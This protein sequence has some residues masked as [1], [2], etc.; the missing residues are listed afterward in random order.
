M[1]EKNEIPASSPEQ[2][3]IQISPSPTKIEDPV[4]TSPETGQAGTEAGQNKTDSARAEQIR[5]NIQSL[6]D[7]EHQLSQRFKDLESMDTKSFSRQEIQAQV[8]ET[9]RL[10]NEIANEKVQIWLKRLSLS[11]LFKTIFNRLKRLF[12]KN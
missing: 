6:A 2:A 3:K 9:A 11:N 5:S 12:S 10:G 8:E 1:G 4:I 7:K